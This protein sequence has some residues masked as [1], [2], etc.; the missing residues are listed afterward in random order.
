VRALSPDRHGQ[1][2]FGCVYGTFRFPTSN[3]RLRL[4]FGEE[5][6]EEEEEEE[7]DWYSLDQVPTT[8]HLVKRK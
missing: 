2:A 1:T 4:E 6:E 7:D 8:S 3:S 5:E